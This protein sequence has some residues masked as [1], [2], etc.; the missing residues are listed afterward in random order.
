[1]HFVRSAFAIEDVSWFSGTFAFAP[2]RLLAAANVGANPVA[3]D[4]L[5]FGR[6]RFFL[7][8]RH[9]ISLDSVLVNNGIG[10]EWLL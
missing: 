5:L 1:L 7:C 8:F 10:A 4:N 3:T 9:F 6:G 2:L